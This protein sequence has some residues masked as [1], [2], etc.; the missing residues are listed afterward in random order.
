MRTQSN[1][2][3]RVGLRQKRFIENRAL[4]GRI[5]FT[6]A[7]A[8]EH[9]SRVVTRERESFVENLI[10]NRAKIAIAQITGYGLQITGY[11]DARYERSAGCLQVLICG[12]KKTPGAIS[13]SDRKIGDLPICE[14]A[15]SLIDRSFDLCLSA[16]LTA[17]ALPAMLF[18]DKILSVGT[19][20]T[21]SCP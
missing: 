7:R 4:K 2:V 13:E 21:E 16:L 5:A 8:R 19:L 3:A 9:C 11:R 17:A 6:R 20:R 15:D 18:L 12:A 1:Q 14:R 10:Y